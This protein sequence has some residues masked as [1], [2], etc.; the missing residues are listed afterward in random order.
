VEAFVG[1]GMITPPVGMCL[2]VACGISGI[3]IEK[4]IRPL[5]PFLLALFVTALII[6]YVPEISLFL[7]RLLGF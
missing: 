4:S 6:S 3:P 1:I 2:Y 5:L 7:P